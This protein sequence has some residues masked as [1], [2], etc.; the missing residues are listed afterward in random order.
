MK[1][2]ITWF[3]YPESSPPIDENVIIACENGNVTWGML[4]KVQLCTKNNKGYYENTKQ[5]ITQWGKEEN[6]GEYWNKIDD[7]IAWA[8]F[9]EPPIK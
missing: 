1:S 9:P 7:V 6:D 3:N 8:Y 4:S 2:E 5:L